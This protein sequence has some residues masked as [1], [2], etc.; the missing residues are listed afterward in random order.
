MIWQD[1][2][3]IGFLVVLE[4]LLSFD[5]A[6]ALAAM[7]RHLPEEQRKKALTYGIWGAFGF[8]FLAL[9]ILTYLLRAVWVKFVGGA[10]LLWMAIHYF[11]IGDA[12]DEE[13]GKNLTAA[14]WKTV[15]LVELTD[16]TFSLDSILASVAVSQ[17]LAIVFTGGVLGIIMMRFV[18]SV[19]IKL[20]DIFPRLEDSAFCLV[21]IVG[22]KL[23]LEGFR[24]S[25]DELTPSVI[26]WS[27]MAVSL[28]YG[29]T[30]RAT[31][32]VVVNDG[33]ARTT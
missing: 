33:T 29:F 13:G 22:A 25:F 30:T 21:G 18:S 31:S 26:F 10:Y 8:R 32:A 27:A 9:T 23:V 12:G 4:G 15:I 16:I 6:L 5:N 2:M 28:L 24:V 20:I 7:V 1:V 19:F 14:F 3:A 17:K 11:F